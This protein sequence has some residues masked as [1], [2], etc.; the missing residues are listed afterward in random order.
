MSREPRYP[1]WDS[2]VRLIHWA[3]ALS[4]PLAW[5]SAELGEMTVHAWVGYTVLCL[6]LTR[7][8][9]GVLGSPQARFADFIRGPRA[10]LAYLRSGRRDT[11][12]HNPLGGWS[13]VA[14]WSLLLVQAGSG[15]FN[16]DEIFF[17]GPFY[18]AVDS[19]VTG[20]LGSVHDTAFNV[21][22]AFVALHLASVAWYQY[23]G[24][25]LLGPMV[26]G[27]EPGREGTAPPAPGGRALLILLLIAL[28]LWMAVSLAPEPVSYW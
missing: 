10:I 26:H 16:S 7:I 8:V 3:L 9:W 19:A 5:A 22:L 23:R 28:A 14:L 2:P 18:Y 12:G 27:A 11:P 25:R 6:V 15:L 4:L 17:D 20:F 24:E 13:S 1:L 21:L